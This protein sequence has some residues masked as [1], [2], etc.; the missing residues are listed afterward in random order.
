MS[1]SKPSSA[2]SKTISVRCDPDTAFH[3]W[4]EQVN[5]WWPAGHSRS[6]NPG[7]RI[8]IEGHIDGRIYERTPEGVEHDWGRVI[9]WDP[10]RRFAYYW[11]LGSSV[12]QPTRVDVRFSAEGQDSTRVDV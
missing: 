10:P 1:P 8:F 12:E 5:T 6:G 3:T 4:T 2:I 9:V 7:T 11:Y